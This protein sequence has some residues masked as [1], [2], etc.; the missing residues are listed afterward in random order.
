[1]PPPVSSHHAAE[2]IV[3]VGDAASGARDLA[4][5][6]ERLGYATAEA[7]SVAE[8][9][10]AR[11]PV[12][13]V[14]SAQD[15]VDPFRGVRAVR[16]R[17]RFAHSLLFA[18]TPPGFDPP[19]G[20]AVAAGADDV[21]AARAEVSESVDR[22][23]GRLVRRRTLHE[24]AMFDCITQIRGRLFVSKWLSAEIGLAVDDHVTASLAV[25]WL[26]GFAAARAERGLLAAEREVEAAAFALSAA[27]RPCDVPCRLSDDTFVVL[28]PAAGKREAAELLEGARE[29]MSVKAASMAVVVAVAEAPS[30]GA[31]WEQLF[32]RA[33][34][35]LEMAAHCARATQLCPT[36]S[37]T[38]AV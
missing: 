21:V 11:P 26:S 22:I 38:S 33:E 35:R 32:E 29:R 10:G 34:A 23:A 3:F 7:P 2:L 24:R 12:A 17:S 28:L 14:V 27:V 30:E 25:L 4:R 36:R 37:A 6:L 20:V 1:M 8:I 31:T 18:W 9:G 15:G 16:T 19:V 5:A 13:V